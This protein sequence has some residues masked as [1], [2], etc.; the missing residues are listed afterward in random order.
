MWMVGV[1][2][3]V[4]VGVGVGQTDHRISAHDPDRLD[5]AIGD[6]LK[7]FDRF[8]SCRMVVKSAPAA[9]TD[10]GG[11]LAEAALPLLRAG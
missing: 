11:F 6:R 9:S 8:S 1:S 2:V 5:L 3:G 4:G 10:P 7:Q